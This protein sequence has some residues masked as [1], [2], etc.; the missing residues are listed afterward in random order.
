MLERDEE[1]KP[2]TELVNMR[3]KKEKEERVL[4][5]ETF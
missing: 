4:E 1:L 2:K 5:D 3:K